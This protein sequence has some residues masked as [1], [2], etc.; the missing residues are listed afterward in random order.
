MSFFGGDTSELLNS[1]VNKLKTE[2][3]DAI[4]KHA[5]QQNLADT[6]LAAVIQHAVKSFTSSLLPAGALGGAIG[7]KATSLLGGMSS[8]LGAAE[9]MGV[10]ALLQKALDSTDVD[11]QLRD[12][13]IDGFARYLRD[14]AGHLAKVALQAIRSGLTAQNG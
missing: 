2:V 6:A 11:E 1:V 3:P 13:L 10:G 4:Y 7:A 5:T 12:A 9:S 8:L 14:N